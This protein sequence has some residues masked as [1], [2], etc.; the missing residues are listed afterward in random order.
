[1]GKIFALFGYNF[2]TFA[3]KAEL[4]IRYFLNIPA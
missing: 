3:V 2:V 1:M 4:D